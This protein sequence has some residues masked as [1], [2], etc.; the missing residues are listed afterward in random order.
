MKLVKCLDNNRVED[1]LSIGRIYEVIEED[2][3][4]YKL[5]N[6]HSLC[7]FFKERF[8]IVNRDKIYELWT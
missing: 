1:F 2:S 3:T 6:Y 7:T 8:E 4:H 5:K